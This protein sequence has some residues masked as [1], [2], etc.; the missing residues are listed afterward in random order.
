MGLHHYK[1]EMQLRD[2]ELNQSDELLG[3]IG[4]HKVLR[5]VAMLRFFIGSDSYIGFV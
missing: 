5:R 3:Q 2:A 4:F 1:I